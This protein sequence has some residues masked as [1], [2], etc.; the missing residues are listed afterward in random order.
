[1]IKLSLALAIIGLALLIVSALPVP[2]TIPIVQPPTPTIP[3]TA[4]PPADIVYGKALFSAKGCATCHHHAAIA[5]SG[6]QDSDI[7]DLTT[8]RWSAD[9]LRTWLK[10]P[11]AIKPTTEMPNLG[12]KRDEIEALI[13]FLSAGT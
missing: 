2:P 11:T 7:P 8:Y 3:P 6:F 9:Y 12:L 1:M 4:A 13:A 10:D 5:H